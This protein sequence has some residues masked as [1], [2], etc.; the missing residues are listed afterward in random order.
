MEL[1]TEVFKHPQALL[2][3]AVVSAKPDRSFIVEKV[4]WLGRYIRKSGEGLEYVLW[5][6]IDFKI[7]EV[8]PF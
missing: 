3:H 7:P 2:T 6:I 8:G 5:G 1:W 4:Q